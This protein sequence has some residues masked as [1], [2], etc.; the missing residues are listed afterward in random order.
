LVEKRA[1][2]AKAQIPEY[3]IVD[4][5][6]GKI[7]VLVLDGS[8]YAVH[9]EFTRGQQATSMLLPGFSV[10]VTTAVAAKR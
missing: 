10:D 7:T 9:G 2:Y 1:D 3:W 8:A 6:L 5:E 4:P